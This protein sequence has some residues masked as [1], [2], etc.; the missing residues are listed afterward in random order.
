MDRK[1][2]LDIGFSNAE[3]EVYFALLKLGSVYSREIVKETELRKSTV[4]ES[5]KR[6]ENKG[7]VSS[8][9]KGGSK[10]FEAASPERIIDY[11]EDKK[12]ELEEK[13][14]KVKKLVLDL[15]SN[16]DVLK[17]KAEAHVLE[18]VEGFK[19]MRRDVLKN[20]C[21]EH[22]LLGAISRENEVIGGFFKDW[23]K[24]RQ[25]KGINMKILHKRS[26]FGKEM[27]DMSFMGE[28]FENKFLPEDIENPA[29]IN[30][31]GDRVVNVLWREN[32]PICFLLINKEIADSYRDYFN[33]LWN[34]SE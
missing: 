5:I 27:S 32:K 11:I 14:D 4:Y 7:M 12:R 33:Y 6:L 28:M 29:V 23:N 19:T 9:I 15:K 31:Y 3:I 16:F 30:I 13:E 2:L 1:V 24:Q 22:L 34:L 21:G 26:A 18:G 25:K 17:P 20:A 10:C 8:V